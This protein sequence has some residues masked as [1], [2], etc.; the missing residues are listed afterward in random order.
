M[1][2]FK[3]LFWRGK[4]PKPPTQPPWDCEGPED[5]LGGFLLLQFF[6]DQRFGLS[7]NGLARFLHDVPIDMRGIVESWIIVYLAWVFRQMTILKHGKAFEEKMMAAVYRRLDGGAGQEPSFKE[8]EKSLRYWFRNLD[9]AAA[10]AV[11]PDPIAGQKLPHAI[12]C[13]LIFLGL[14]P[15][16]PY[17]MKTEFSSDISRT[18]SLA[19][20]EA[21][22]ARRD[23]I[24]YAV[25]QAPERA[26][27]S[28]GRRPHKEPPASKKK[29][30]AEI[31][32]LILL[33]QILWRFEIEDDDFDRFIKVVDVELRPLCR[34]WIVIYCA[35]MLMVMARDTFGKQFVEN[36]LAAM[37]VEAAA[38]PGPEEMQA[39]VERLRFWFQ[40]LDKELNAEPVIVKGVEVPRNVFMALRFLVLDPQSPHY[41]KQ[42][43]PGSVDWDVGR[44]LAA[45]NDAMLPR[46]QKV[47]SNVQVVL[48]EIKRV[49]QC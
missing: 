22:D 29:A 21:Q 34:E 30:G 37:A 40:H 43:L 4:P 1:G 9:N 26:R 15:G 39:T 3:S 16:S 18:I 32:A 12:Y 19:L 27:I 8:I 7:E 20:S 45:T 38:F 17:Y 41:G 28:A 6:P 46:V 23:F 25:V 11:E 24:E 33:R 31:L 10:K 35:W 5:F 13:S 42:E 47:M 48:S 14:D 49:N 36:A 2:I 44:A